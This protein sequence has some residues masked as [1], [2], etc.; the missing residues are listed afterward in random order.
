M[1]HRNTSKFIASYVHQSQPFLIFPEPSNSQHS[2][3]FHEI[4]L[5]GSPEA[6]AYSNTFNCK[7]NS[8]SEMQ[9]RM[10]TEAS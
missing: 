6:A 4:V 3:H 2:D 5:I 10:E 1:T 8:K 9:S 7:S